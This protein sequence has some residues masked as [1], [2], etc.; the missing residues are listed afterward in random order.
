MA[1][2]GRPALASSSLL[3]VDSTQ[4]GPQVTE[5]DACVPPPGTWSWRSLGGFMTQSLIHS[6]AVRRTGRSGEIAATPDFGVCET[7]WPSCW[8]L[9]LASESAAFRQ[10]SLGVLLWTLSPLSQDLF[11]PTPSPLQSMR[12]FISNH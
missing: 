12:C 4:P 6:P 10:S 5:E 7:L 2:E 9:K 1:W 8:I 11:W 3:S